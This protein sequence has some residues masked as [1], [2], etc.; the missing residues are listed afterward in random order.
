MGRGRNHT[1]QTQ[2]DVPF[3]N[4]HFKGEYTGCN[5]LLE[6]PVIQFSMF[7]YLISLMTYQVNFMI[8]C[9]T[10]ITFGSFK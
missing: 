4:G 3:W 1:G 10:F 6:K 8:L 5:M 2:T 7:P 9:S